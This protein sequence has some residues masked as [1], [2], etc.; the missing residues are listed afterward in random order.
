MLVDPLQDGRFV[1]VLGL[2]SDVVF[3]LTPPHSS[4]H[5]NDPA[6]VAMSSW[7]DQDI[8]VLLKRRGIVGIAGEARNPW[9]HGI[10][11]GVEVG[12]HGICDWFGSTDTLIPRRSER[13]SIVFAFQ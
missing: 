1:F 8:D 2:Q 12:E 5:R 9:R 4:A 11:T 10:R 7:S 6:Q 3:T 13:T